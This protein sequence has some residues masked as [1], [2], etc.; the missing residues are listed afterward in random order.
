M[1]KHVVFLSLLLWFGSSCHS[2]RYAPVNVRSQALT[3]KADS[4]TQTQIDSNNWLSPYRLKLSTALDSPLFVSCRSVTKKQPESALGNHLTQVMRLSAAKELKLPIDAA[5]LNYGGIRAALPSGV[6]RM[7]HIF[8]I[9]PFDNALCVVLLDS[10]QML[11][12]A[13]YWIASKGHP[14]DGFRVKLDEQ[15]RA[16]IDWSGKT[17]TYPIKIVVTDYIANGGDNASFFKTI[18]DRKCLKQPLR[19]ALIEYYRNH[20]SES[21]T[22]C[23]PKD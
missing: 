22:L 2:K 3:L 20:Y 5:M 8:E 14:I 19:E 10:S 16:F 12:F 13:Q 18:K 4:S 7:R 17:V 9:M 15:K 1:M 6:V 23:L 11:T 21:D